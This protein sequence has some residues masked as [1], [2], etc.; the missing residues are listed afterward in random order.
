[1]ILLKDEKLL[2]EA[3]IKSGESKRSF[4]NDIG[5]SQT[6]LSLLCKGERNPGAKTAISICQKLNI[7]FD[8]LFTIVNGYNSKH[9]EA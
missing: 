7:E 1:M 9:K 6:M 8:V 4:A 2:N 3:I 5:I